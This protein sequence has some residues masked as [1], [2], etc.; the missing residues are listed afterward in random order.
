MDSVHELME[1]KLQVIY[2]GEKR[3]VEI[4]QDVLEDVSDAKLRDALEH[5]LKETEEQVGRVEKVFQSLGARARTSDPA[6]IEGIVEERR[7][8]LREDA[9]PMLVDAF[10]VGASMKVEHVEIAQYEEII[11]LA[12][13]AGM[14]DVVAPLRKNLEEERAA[15]EKLRTIG[16]D[17]KIEAPAREAQ[18]S[19]EAR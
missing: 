6:T 19:V 3:T 15:L 18:R 4:I 5:H 10:V 16:T 7:R 11:L 2:A 13:R 1:H 17:L 8:F 12:E 14:A 9:T